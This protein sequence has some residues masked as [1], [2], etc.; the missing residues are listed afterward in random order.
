M[1]KEKEVIKGYARL[2]EIWQDMLQERQIAEVFRL[3]I[4]DGGVWTM[5]DLVEEGSLEK[6]WMLEAEKL[7][8][9]FRETRNLF[10]ASRVGTL[11]LPGVHWQVI[12]L[13]S[14]QINFF[15]GMFPKKRTGGKKQNEEESEERMASR[16]Q[17]DLGRIFCL[18]ISYFTDIAS[19][20]QKTS[21]I[22]EIE[23]DLTALTN[24]VVF[25]SKIGYV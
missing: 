6:E 24:S 17:L 11:L 21:R 13:P 23:Q 12:D 9:A 7:V 10:L 16:L 8:E 18:R 15:R 22:A 20:T 5:V 2:K 14:S 1:E 19:G 4:A 25:R 3:S